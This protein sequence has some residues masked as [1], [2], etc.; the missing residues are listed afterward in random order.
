MV[1][2]KAATVGRRTLGSI[3]G[4]GGL[5]ARFPF[6]EVRLSKGKAVPEL[7]RLLGQADRDRR[8]TL[9]LTVSYHQP[10][11]LRVTETDPPNYELQASAS[12]VRGDAMRVQGREGVSC[13]LDLSARLGVGALRDELRV[14]AQRAEK[15]VV[16]RVPSRKRNLVELVPDVDF[17]L[18]ESDILAAASMAAAGTVLRAEDFS[19]WEK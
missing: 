16:L 4:S 18:G 9:T 15:F 5:F 10:D 6:Y 11:R 19:D 7:D 12:Y 14:A 1:K 17:G 3:N 13:N 8:C 2:S